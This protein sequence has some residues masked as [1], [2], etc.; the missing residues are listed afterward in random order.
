MKTELELRHLRAFVTVVETGGHTRAARSLGVSQSTVSETLSSLERTLGADLFRKGGKGV[1][2]TRTGEALL[3]YARRILA[4]TGELAAQLAG[5]TSQ[6]KATLTV[7]AVESIS[8]Y[9]L[10]PHLAALREKWPGVRLEVAARVCAEIRESVTAGQSD[11]GLVLEVGGGG[12]DASDESA[13]ATARLVIFG[14]PAHP[15]AGGG[16]RRKAS[17]D[18]LRRCDFYMSDAAGDYHHA[19][20]RHFEAAGAPP[21]RTQVLGSVEGVKRGILTG[22]AASRALG[23]LPAHAVKQ[24]LADGVFAEVRVNPPLPGLVLRAVLGP[25]SADSPLVDELVRRLRG[26]ALG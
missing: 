10:P 25:E 9:V 5:V 26:L 7:A 6:V 16:V 19:L 11:L 17:A 23:L 15:L 4:L 3:P 22:G 1:A 12:S 13:L 20:R 8:T 21:P 18:E 2:L 24:E 14:A